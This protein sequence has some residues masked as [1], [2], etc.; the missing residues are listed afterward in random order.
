[1]ESLGYA[2]RSAT[3]RRLRLFTS[4]VSWVIALSAFARD[5]LV[6]VGFDPSRMTV[7]PN[8]VDVPGTPA[9][10]ACGEFV[11]FSGRMSPE[12]GVSTLLAAHGK[13]PDIPLMLAGGGPE[14]E[15]HKSEALPSVRFSGQ[16]SKAD[17]AALYRRARLLV[18]PS[19][20]FEGCPLVV[21]EAMSHGV[22]VLASRIGGLPE[23][24]ED[25]VSGALFEVGNFDELAGKMNALWSDPMLCR[26]MGLAARH[27]AITA[28][29]KN[30]YWERLRGA[31]QGALDV[32]NRRT[33]ESED[34]TCAGLPGEPS[35]RDRPG[36]AQT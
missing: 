8:F 3:A 30:L 31:Y 11:M 13:Q 32:V 9:D 26:K 15:K 27:R 24:L 1:V 7:L 33:R 20:C 17:L 36:S 35:V 4:N 18:V 29:D 14:L 6:G 21:L 10:P 23:L 16:V 28:H 2:V 5:R 34:G 12:K 22:P 25:G 19:Q